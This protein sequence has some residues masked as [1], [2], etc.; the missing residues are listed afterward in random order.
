MAGDWLKIEKTLP[1]KPEVWQIAGILDLDPDAVVGKLIRV[2]SWFDEHTEYGNAPSVTELLLDRLVSVTGFTKALRVS[3]WIFTQGDEIVLRNFTRHNGKTA[4][5]RATAQKRQEK[6]RHDNVTTKCKPEK[7][8]EE[9]NI[10]DKKTCSIEPFN[11]FDKFY[12]G[13]PRK[14][15]KQAAQ[16]AWNKLKPDDELQSLITQDIQN[17]INANHWDLSQKDYIPHPSTYLNQ[18]RWTDEITPRGNP[19]AK[20]RSNGNSETAGR[21]LTPSERVAAKHAERYG[22]DT[23]TGSP[24]LETVVAVQ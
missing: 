8:R 19:N 7:R 12:A 24:A 3:G 4:K 11:G 21:K 15:N 6:Y 1:E 9:K 20:I 22:S 5:T 23:A 14:S 10:R 17:R 18:K 2:F 13:Y 16:Q